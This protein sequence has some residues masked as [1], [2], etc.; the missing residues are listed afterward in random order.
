M[1]VRSDVAHSVMRRRIDAGNLRSLTQ[2]SR[3]P[4]VAKTRRV[5][6]CMLS[7]HPGILVAMQSLLSGPNFSPSPLRLKIGPGYDLTAVRL[8]HAAVYVLD[9]DSVRPA[10]ESLIEMIQNRIPMARI[11]VVVETLQDE[12]L[13]PY[14]RVGAKGVIRYED[15][16]HDLARSVRVVAAGGYWVP[17]IQLSRFLDSIVAPPRNF[18]PQGA[19][20]PL[21]RREREVHV[22]ILQGLSNKEIGTKMNIS[23]RT[24][25]FHVSNLLSKC[26]AQRRMDLILKG[27][28]NWSSD[29]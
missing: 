21:S 23:E 28:G 15:L 13:F 10:T 4:E 1:I 7:S 26:G 18:V 27:S 6:V 8:P 20:G 17:R 3:L 16:R 9:A 14:L 12:G 19:P 25:K 11:V 5:E 29:A 24:V 2:N 22:A